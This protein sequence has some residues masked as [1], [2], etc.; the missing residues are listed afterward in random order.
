MEVNCLDIETSGLAATDQLLSFTFGTGSEFGTEQRIQS[1]L[2]TTERNV[3]EMLSSM[4][5]GENNTTLITFNGQPK[6]G[7]ML[8]FDIPFL[9]TRYIVN[10][11]PE[12]YPFTGMQHI[13]V[14]ELAKTLNTRTYTAPVPDDLSADQTTQLINVLGLHPAKT[15]KGNVT[16]LESIDDPKLVAEMNNYLNKYVESKPKE[17]NSLDSI[18]QLLFEEESKEEDVEDD[19]T[20]KDVPLIWAQYQED[21]NEQHLVR[22]LNH[23]LV[24]VKKTVKIFRC[25][26]PMVTN[27]PMSIL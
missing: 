16:Q 25:L 23:N 18:Y 5:K 21:N 2:G 26:E 27:M 6:Y 10:K 3:L 15:K 19:M 17:H 14:M 1:V 9:R 13:D 4:V 20:G 12:L 7:S 11:I 22:I 24:D 8:G